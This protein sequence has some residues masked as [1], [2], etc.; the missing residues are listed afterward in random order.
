MGI[1]ALDALVIITYLF[2]VAGLGLALRGRQEGVADYFLGSRRIAWPLILLSIVA[3]ET[4]TVTFL[5]V[6]GKA[7]AGDMT[8]LQL[9]MGYVVG[10][11]GV[12]LALMPLYFRRESLTLYQMLGTRFGPSVQRLTATLFI[13]TRTV[14]DGLRLYL[15]A[16]VV[17]ELTGWGF[18]A[19][20]LAVG[21]VTI[22]YTFLGGIRAVIWTD[23]TQFFIYMLGAVLAG[24]VLL[25]RVPGGWH[26]VL[27]AGS[28]SGK[29][30]ILNL[31]L[32]PSAQSLWAGIV[33]GAFLTAATHGA[34]QM[35]VQRYLCTDS[36][37]H[38]R[39][40]LMA[41][42]VLVLAQFALF[43][44]IGIGLFAFY[45]AD[46]PA[47]AS[48]AV[49]AKFIVEEVPAGLSGL[50]IAAVFSAAMST[51]SSSLNSVASAA[52]GDLYR[53]LVRPRASEAHYLNASRCFTIA[54]GVLQMA[55]AFYGRRLQH[56]STVDNVLDIAAFTT[57]ITL[58]VLLLGIVVRRASGP[59]AVFA[60]LAGTLAVTL[61]W[62]KTPISGWW[63]AMI[64]SGTTLLAGGLAS[65]LL[66]RPQ[67]EP[68]TAEKED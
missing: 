31:A 24:W 2:G 33:G 23:F 67:G 47:V 43:L 58:G 50:V 34:D 22:A 46:P 17:R 59:A 3:T 30:R 60:M 10:R 9:A 21:L 39:L 68:A 53:P 4:S 18:E 25:G 40:A 42:G 29:F 32:D 16:L 12:A 19:S 65:W 62:L 41:S 8:F 35:M 54:A 11:C 44:L 51:L 52:I 55:V 56:R 48:D 45:R 27:D 38:A 28:A 63:Y 5:S 1:N 64:G 49:F 36:V 61:V 57:G 7:Y 13:A 15:T 26:A 14:A 20:V 6:P 66:P 37:R